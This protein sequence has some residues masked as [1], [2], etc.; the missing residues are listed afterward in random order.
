[1][2]FQSKETIPDVDMCEHAVSSDTQAMFKEEASANLILKTAQP[3]LPS[4]IRKEVSKEDREHYIENNL[5]VKFLTM[6]SHYPTIIENH[7]KV[8]KILDTAVEFDEM[9]QVNKYHEI[10]KEFLMWKKSGRISGSVP[11]ST[12]REWIVDDGSYTMYTKI[13][14]L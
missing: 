2:E 1:M 10:I 8:K 11:V 4:Q 5:L 14:D 3:V 12:F 6:F 9:S 7:L 13:Q